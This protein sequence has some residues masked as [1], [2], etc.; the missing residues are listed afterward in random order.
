[1]QLSTWRVAGLVIGETADTAATS[2]TVHEKRK[3]VV[4]TKMSDGIISDKEKTVATP[5]L[6]KRWRLLDDTKIIFLS[7]RSYIPS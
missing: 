6:T 4:M 7:I 2:N 1:L 5:S 3:N